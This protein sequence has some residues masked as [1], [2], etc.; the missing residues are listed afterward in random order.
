[1]SWQECVLGFG[2]VVLTVFVLYG[3]INGP[4]PATL[5]CFSY[6][7]VLWLF[8]AV[9]SSEGAIIASVFAAAQAILWSIWIGVPDGRKNV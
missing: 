2:N 1:M 8:S 7:T 3:F 4:R 6:A 5:M 9:F